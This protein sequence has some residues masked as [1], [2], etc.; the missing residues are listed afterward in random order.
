MLAVLTAGNALP[1][2]PLWVHI[3]Y[4]ALGVALPEKDADAPVCGLPQELL[5][6]DII[7]ILVGEG[8]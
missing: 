3:T 4:D 2:S 1:T 8:R 7:L 5:H 6:V